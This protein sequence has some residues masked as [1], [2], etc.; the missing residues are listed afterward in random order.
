[1]RRTILALFLLSLVPV[2]LA[3]ASVNVVTTTEDLAALTREVGGDKVK[4]ESLARGK[5]VAD[6]TDA[7]WLNL[8]T[9][10][11]VELGADAIKTDYTGD[12]ESMRAVVRGCPIPILVLGGSRLASDRDALAIVRGAVEAGAAG[13]FFGRNVF[14]SDNIKAFLQ[15]ARAVLDGSSVPA[16]Q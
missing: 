12:P 5:N 1:M 2:G 6:Y 15:Q 4:V 16:R 3:T 8:H 10:M 7:K 14:Q 13:V 9:R 11:A